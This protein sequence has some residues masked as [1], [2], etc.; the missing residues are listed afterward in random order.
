[1]TGR[2]HYK[3]LGVSPDADPAHIRAA[4]VSLLKRYH[5]DQAGAN[6][7]QDNGTQIQRIVRA[8][9]IL[10][11]PTTRAG[12]D[13]TLRRTA[14]PTLLLKSTPQ[15]AGDVRGTRRRF[16]LDTDT[17]S[18]VLMLVAAAVGLH[19]LVSRLL[20]VPTLRPAGTLLAGMSPARGFPAPA[21]LE[22]VVRNAG[23]VSADEASNYS[24]R[25]FAAARHSRNP[26]AADPCVGF[27]MAYVYLRDGMGGP[28]VLDS[29][30]QPDVM[31]SRASDAFSGL[32][33][34]GAADRVQSIR[35]ATFRAIMLAPDA[36]NEF[37]RSSAPSQAHTAA[38]KQ[39]IKET[40]SQED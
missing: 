26:I 7:T 10:K 11:D 31:S 34:N 3:V 27:D 12:Y 17:I 8:Y 15:R 21:H 25:C 35:T 18:Y 29:Y 37:S 9:R 30:F 5:P 23:M 16:R 20:E 39:A 1:M 38:A 6:G 2:N 36:A 4:Y 32:D 24:S 28:L 40:P 19:L 13:A 33:P 14:R 22:A